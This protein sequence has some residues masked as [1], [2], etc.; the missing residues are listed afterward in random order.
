MKTVTDISITAAT[1]ALEADWTP[2]AIFR[3]PKQGAWFDPSDIS[4]LFQDV[5]ATVPV[6]ADGDPVAI[7]RDKSGHGNDAVQT[8]AARRP[9]WRSDGTLAW[10]EFDGV[11]DR[12]VCSPMVFETSDSLNCCAGMSYLPGGAAWGALRSLVANGVYAGLSNPSITGTISNSGG[13]YSLNAAVA[14][15][16]RKGLREA[17][18]SPGV[19]AGREIQTSSFSSQP[20]QFFSYWNTSPPGGRLFGY[21]EYEGAA[22]PEFVILRAWMAK[23]TGAVA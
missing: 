10:L 8:N 1:K 5:A 11:D 23:K 22:G 17:L 7:M 21:V 13:A 14:P 3:H 19:L 20:W 6:S 4:T 2:D 18:F 12:M 16:D 15:N 9:T